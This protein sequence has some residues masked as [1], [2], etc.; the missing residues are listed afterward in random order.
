MDH[1]VWLGSRTL[2]TVSSSA[3]SLGFGLLGMWVRAKILGGGNFS[4][5]KYVP[6][7]SVGGISSQCLSGQE[8]GLVYPYVYPKLGLE[9]CSFHSFIPSAAH[10]V[11]IRG[12]ARHGAGYVPA[13]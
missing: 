1:W 9:V 3:L 4:I 5:S 11:C 2:G 13:P 7:N 10:W 6:G 8:G 12:W